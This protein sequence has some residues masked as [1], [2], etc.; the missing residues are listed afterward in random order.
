MDIATILGI[1]LAWGAVVVALLMEGGNLK[2]MVSPSSAILVFGGTIGATIVSFTLK[3]VTGLPGALRQAFLTKK[4]DSLSVIRLIVS[5]SRKARQSGI[6]ALESEIEK[7]ENL[8]IRQAL[9]LVVDGIQP[10]MVRETLETEVAAMAARH[11]VGEDFF[12]TM[13]GFAPT[14]GIIGTVMGLVHMLENLDK[15]GGMGPAIAAAFIATLYGVMSAN[16]LF[17]PLAGKLKS[18]SHEEVALYELA[19]EGILMLQAGENP[20]VV[21]QKMRAFLSPDAKRQ[22]DAE[23]E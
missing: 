23:K 13:G 15:P 22:L 9:Q 10:E 8:F 20:H 5:L 18:R 12:S 6:L 21:S 11:K 4:L 19:I 3:H 14:L 17:L 2:S 7:I 16:L 1:V